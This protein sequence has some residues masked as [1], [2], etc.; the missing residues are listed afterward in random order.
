MEMSK[1][2]NIYQQNLFVKF[3]ALVTFVFIKAKEVSPM[4]HI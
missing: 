1:I 3:H 4:C 2:F